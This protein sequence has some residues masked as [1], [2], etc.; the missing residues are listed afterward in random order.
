MLTEKQL[1]DISN[2]LS[3]ILGC[4]VRLIHEQKSDNLILEDS[5]NLGDK[6][7]ICNL[8][9]G[10]ITYIMV[11]EDEEPLT[12]RELNLIKKFITEIV[13]DVKYLAPNITEKDVI[14]ILTK[15]TDEKTV[16]DIMK[17]LGFNMNED[18]SVILVKMLSNSMASQVASIVKHISTNHLA[19]VVISEDILA[20]IYQKNNKEDID[21]EKKIVDAVESELLQ[22]IKI[23]VSS[24]KEPIKVKEAYLESF[25]ALNIGLEHQLPNKI[26][27]YR[28]LLVYR[29]ISKVSENT[30]LKLYKE[31]ME[32]GL[33]KLSNEEIKTANIFLNS[34]LNISEAARKLYVHRNT[35]NYRLD[36]IQ[37]DTGFDIRVFNDAIKFKT[38]LVIYMYMNN[39]V[40]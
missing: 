32:L 18:I 25:E 1:K 12:N 36:K 19:S 5:E 6:H 28:E 17:H 4:N 16:E 8:K 3:Y 34:N 26:Y 10:G 11:V 14:R 21:L 35:L 27:N 24:L 30:V 13:E 37:K 9:L 7:N 2:R 39:K 22:N 15:T 20:V 29:L 40:K 38:L 23:G 31:A 33:H